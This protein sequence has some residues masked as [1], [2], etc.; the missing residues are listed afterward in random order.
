MGLIDRLVPGEWPSRTGIRSC[1]IDDRVNRLFEQFNGLGVTVSIGHLHV[2]HYCTLL[3]AAH[4]VAAALPSA[5]VSHRN[6][7]C[8]KRRVANSRTNGSSSATSMR[9]G[10]PFDPLGKSGCD[11]GGSRNCITDGLQQNVGIERFLDDP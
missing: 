1:H 6:P 5:E 7:E 3:L 10:N 9:Y 11:F 4:C 8:M 2:G